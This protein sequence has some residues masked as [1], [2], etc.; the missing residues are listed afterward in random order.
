MPPRRLRG[1][2]A[3]TNNGIA[4]A[5]GAP[6]SRVPTAPGATQ[7]GIVGVFN[8]GLINPFSLTQTTA[9]L[10]ALQAVS[11][12]GA[13]L[14]GGKYEV[15]Q[16]DASVSGKLFALPGGMVQVA[17]GI[18]YRR[19]S[20][21][22]DG[23]SAGAVSSPDIFNAAFD[24]IN[25]LNQVTRD[26]KAAYAEVLFRFSKRWRL[27]SPGGSTTTPASGR[28]SIPRSASSSSRCRG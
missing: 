5:S 21:K 28:P 24:N 22:F 2:T 25:A 16:F 20:Y 18:D 10:A 19:E 12:R 4:P 15:K 17:A 14:Y 8:A 9:G 27:P 11:A 6:D 23:S 7:P 13:R 1:L 3:A 26:V